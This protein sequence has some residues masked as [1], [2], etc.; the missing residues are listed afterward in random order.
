LKIYF[1]F[2]FPPKLDCGVSCHSVCSS[3]VPAHCGQISSLI[4]HN[5]FLLK[6]GQVK[7]VRVRLNSGKTTDTDDARTITLILFTDCLLV[8]DQ[9]G[10]SE[11]QLDGK[12]I[13][14]PCKKIK[15]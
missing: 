13:N 10:T 12:T 3:S 8:C 5:R 1:I 4:K 14:F 11:Y 15:V 6:D 9:T 2:P 7:T